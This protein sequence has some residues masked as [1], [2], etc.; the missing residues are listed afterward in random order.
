MRVGVSR[1]SASWR[2]AQTE[3]RPPA[4]PRLGH[5]ACAQVKKPG[6]RRRRAAKEYVAR[7]DV[8]ARKPCFRVRRPHRESTDGRVGTEG[9]PPEHLARLREA[10]SALIHVVGAWDDAAHPHPAGLDPRQDLERLDLDFGLADLALVDRGLE[11][12]AA[13]GGRHGTPAEREANERE[14]AILRRLKV[15]LEA[16]GPL[17]D[18]RLDPGDERRSAAS[19]SLTRNPVLVLLNVGERPGERPE[20]VASIRCG[21]RPPPRRSSTFPQVEIGLGE[22]EP[23]EAAVDMEE[24]ELTRVE[25]QPGDRLSYQLWAWSLPHR[26]PGRG[27]RVAGARRVDRG[28][29]GRYDPHRPRRGFIRAETFA[30]EDLLTLGSMGGARRPTGALEGR[31]SGQG[32]RRH[33]DPVQPLTAADATQRR[34]R[35]SSTRSPAGRSPPP[36]PSSCSRRPR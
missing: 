20:V 3:P 30:Y 5:G 26:R 34:G 14:E 16:G 19:S 2:P 6:A 11:R 27:P 36:I 15:V 10:G 8:V 25:P 7:T 18:E 35:V 32:R 17:R 12:L 23:G 33:R 22:L 21:L 29:R 28:R 1:A 31:T 9:L 4:Q 24:L 13:G